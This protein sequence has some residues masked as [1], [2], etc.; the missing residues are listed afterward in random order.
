[1]ETQCPISGPL[2]LLVRAFDS[3][4]AFDCLN[5]RAGSISKRS[6]H[7]TPKQSFF[8]TFAQRMA[9]PKGPLPTPIGV[10]TLFVTKLIGVTVLLPAVLT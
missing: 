1:M 9:M 6:A 8:R 2:T 4:N 3:L 5:A 10:S 7:V